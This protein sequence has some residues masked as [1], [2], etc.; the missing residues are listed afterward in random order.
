[1]KKVQLILMFIHNSIVI[2]IK[3]VISHSIKKES[4]NV[5]KE[6]YGRIK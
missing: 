6:K 1:M 4:K 3:Q 2:H 5:E